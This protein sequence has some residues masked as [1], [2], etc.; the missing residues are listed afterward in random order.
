MALL[1]EPVAAMISMSQIN[2]YWTVNPLDQI[3]LNFSIDHL[4]AYSIETF[5]VKCNPSKYSCI[6]SCLQIKY[7][8]K[9]RLV[10]LNLKKYI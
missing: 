7:K 5:I 8:I 9:Q 3:E 6:V 10:H 2:V 4:F 1:I